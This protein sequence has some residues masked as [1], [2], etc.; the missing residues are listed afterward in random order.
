VVL[1]LNILVASAATALVLFVCVEVPWANT[2][3]WFFALILS[4]GGKAK[5]N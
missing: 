1:F 4:G 3:K 5:K 2:E